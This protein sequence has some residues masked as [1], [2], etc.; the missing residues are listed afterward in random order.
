M[1]LKLASR[2]AGMVLGPS[3]DRHERFREPKLQDF[4]ELFCALV[5][6]GHPLINAAGLPLP[7]DCRHLCSHAV[8]SS[9]V[10]RRQVELG[11]KHAPCRLSDSR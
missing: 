1:F 2:E 4:G 6:I 3:V 10:Q 9:L 5:L 7:T 8:D 11:R